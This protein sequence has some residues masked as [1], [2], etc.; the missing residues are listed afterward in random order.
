MVH[1]IMPFVTEELWQN[2]YN[3]NDNES[4]C[5]AE[6]P[7]YKKENIDLNIEKEFNILQLLIESI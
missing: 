6:F 7:K 2:I 5:I 4:I 1:P 3:R